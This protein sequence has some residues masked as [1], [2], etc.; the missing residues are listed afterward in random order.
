MARTYLSGDNSRGGTTTAMGGSHAHYR[1]WHAGVRVQDASMEG[2]PDRFAVYMTDGSAGNGIDTLIGYVAETPDGPAWTPHE[3]MRA[4][5]LLV[6]LASLDE[7]LE[8][9]EAPE[10]LASLA[11]AARDLVGDHRPHEESSND[12]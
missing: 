8:G 7:A 4:N 10:I 11:E 2:K 5:D 1:G 6:E 12:A 9:D 3:E